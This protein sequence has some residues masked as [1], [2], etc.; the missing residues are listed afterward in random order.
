MLRKKQ[1]VAIVSI[2]VVSFLIGTSM[3]TD[4]GNPFDKMWEAISGLQSETSELRT[5]YNN[6]MDDFTELKNNLTELTLQYEELKENVTLALSRAPDYDSG[7][8]DVSEGEI[9]TL[10]HD[11]GT[12]ELFVYMLG[13]GG[14]LEIHQHHYGGT[15]PAGNRGLRWYH[16]TENTIQVERSGNDERWE[17]FHIM[18]WKIQEPPT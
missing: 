1:V 18:I 4:G 8:M 7:W 3:A 10:T 12:T 9:I 11:L 14:G 5:D 6:L 16:L 17:Q 2:V 13:Q 15:C